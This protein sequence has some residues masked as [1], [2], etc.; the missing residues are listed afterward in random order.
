MRN[1]MML[2]V[3]CC[4]LI[5][6]PAVEQRTIGNREEV[7]RLDG[8]EIAAWK[9]D[10][11]VSRVMKAAEVPGVGLAILNDGK[12][13]YLK[14]YGL[15]DKETNL[16]MTPQTV[17]SAA[18]FTKVAFGDMVMQLVDQGKLN[19]DKPVYEYLPKPLPE[20]ANYRDLAAD[21]RYKKIVAR[22]LLSHTS[23]FPNWRWF[24]EDRKLNIA[25]DPGSRYAYSGEGLMLLQ[26]VVETITGKPLTELM[27]TRV[28][29]PFGMA[30]TSMVWQA[31]FENDYA[32]GYDEHGRSLGPQRREKADAAGSML[33]TVQDFARFLQAVLES[34]GMR[35]ETRQ[36]ML[37]PQI[38][39]SSKHEFP[40]FSTETTDENKKIKLSYGLTWGLYWTPYGKVFFKEGHD[41]GHMN[42]AVCF[43]EKKNCVVMMT[44][45]SNGEG[46]YEELLEKLQGNTYTPIEWEGF[47]PYNEVPKARTAP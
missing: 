19:L 25:F 18:S 33:T 17:M 3:P 35:K 16:P 27:Q 39:I 38:A 44:N 1:R 6:I 46:I 34:N 15:R 42:Y 37:S 47:K 20:Y 24:N 14:G 10:A 2:L 45:S 21:V 4:V 31:R 23:G 7:K 36:L 22:M 29:E 5:T 28:F 30:R 43:E 41:D 8:S 40:T 9:I 12:I 11:T 26:L 32:N 13:V